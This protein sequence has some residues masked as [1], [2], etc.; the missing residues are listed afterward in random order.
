MM[1]AGIHAPSVNLTTTTVPVTA[2]VVREPT[3][4]KNARVCQ[5]G[6]FSFRCRTSIP[7]WLSVKPVNTPTAYSGIKALTIPPNAITN[8]DAAKPKKITP[9]ENT[10]RSPRLASWR[11]K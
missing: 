6:S 4:E 11:G 2:N 10:S 8:A 7:N 3:P 1:T 5:P 9:F